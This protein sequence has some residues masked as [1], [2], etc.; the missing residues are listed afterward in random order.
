MSLYNGLRH[1]DAYSS[2]RVVPTCDRVK[3]CMTSSDG[4]GI[5]LMSQLL[6]HLK[7]RYAI[8]LKINSLK[9]SV[10]VQM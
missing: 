4:Q 9:Y 2:T 3:A 1:S 7:F 8:P 5:A 10:K 6:G